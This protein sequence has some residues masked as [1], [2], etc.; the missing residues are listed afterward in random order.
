MAKEPSEWRDLLICHLEEA[1][2]P[3]RLLRLKWLSTHMD[4]YLARFSGFVQLGTVPITRLIEGD[5]FI[6]IRV[7]IDVVDKQLIEEPHIHA[8]IEE[9]W[10][11]FKN[12]VIWM[13]QTQDS[14]DLGFLL[15]TYSRFKCSLLLLEEAD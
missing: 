10:S 3:T 2:L 8:S 7:A 6:I 13:Q 9:R 1:N 12:A 4:E 14:T 5:L 15:D 11:E